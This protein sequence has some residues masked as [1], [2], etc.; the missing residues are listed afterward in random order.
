[1]IIYLRI[2]KSMISDLEMAEL[3]DP[4]NLALLIKKV[5]YCD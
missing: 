5:I 1:M 2:Q 4:S 3:M